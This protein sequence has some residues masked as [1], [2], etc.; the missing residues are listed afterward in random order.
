MQ[1]RALNLIDVL[2]LC[3]SKLGRDECQSW[4]PDIGIHPETFD[5]QRMSRIL[6]KVID[7]VQ[8]SY[9][10]QELITTETIAAESTDATGL[11]KYPLPVNCLRPLGARC[12]TQPN[13]FTDFY[14]YYKVEGNYLLSYNED[15]EIAY[16]KREDDPSKWTSELLDCIEAKAA[17]DACMMILDDK[18]FRRELIKEYNQLTIQSAKR[19][20]AKYKTNYS[21]YLPSG[22]VSIYNYG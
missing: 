11:I 4:Q 12:P 14:D 6:L 10:W 8:R 5:G 21:K 7:D 2:N 20:Q 15:I 13:V 9:F 3:L 16:I 1:G 22:F 19:L 18:V 17:A